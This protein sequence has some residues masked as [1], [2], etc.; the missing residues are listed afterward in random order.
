LADSSGLRPLLQ[1]VHKNDYNIVDLDDE[2]RVDQ[3][4]VGLVRHFNLHLT[5]QGG[6][7]PEQAGELCLGADYF[8]REFIIADRRQNIFA[9]EAERVRQFAGHWYITRTTEPNLTELQSIL[10]GTAGFYSYLADQGLINSEIAGEIDVQ[11]REFDYYQKRIDDF[12]SIEGEGFDAW[13]QACPLEPV[14]DI[15]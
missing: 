9:I 4:C 8:L 6:L 14:P 7:S 12:W 11:C 3:L 2:I 13:R 5:Q 1:G 10:K 15:S